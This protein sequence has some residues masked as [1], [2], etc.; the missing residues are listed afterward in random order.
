MLLHNNTVDRSKAQECKLD[1][2]LEQVRDHAADQDAWDMADECEYSHNIHTDMADECEYSHNIHTDMA[3][4]CEYSH[5]IHTDM[6][7]EC[8][9]SHN[10]HTDMA[11]E[12]EYSHNIHTDM[13]DECE[14]SHNIHTDM[15]DECKYSHN[16]H[17]DMADECEYSH[18][19]HTDM[20]DECEY[21]HNIHTDMADECEY[22]HNIHT[23]QVQV[24][25]Y[26]AVDLGFDS[27]LHCAFFQIESDRWLKNG[28]P[29]ATLPGAWRYRVSAGTGWPSSILWLGEIESLIRNFC[30][31]VAACKIVRTDPSLRYAS[32]L[33]RH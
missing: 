21:S 4:E 14:Y 10:I 18:N 24:S 32:M 13:A 15:T 22:S 31:S 16:I 29:V 26:R 9:Y 1:T 17:T 23:E 12:C 28:A 30:L 20:A 33:L 27:C 7:D 8:E 2:V 3:D 6:A 5:N 11:D 19:I 25:A